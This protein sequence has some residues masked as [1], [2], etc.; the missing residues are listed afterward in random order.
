MFIQFFT[1]FIHA[2]YTVFQVKKRVIYI[3]LTA[4][5]INSRIRIRQIGYFSVSKA[6]G[7]VFYALLVVF[8][9]KDPQKK[10]NK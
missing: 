8:G 9:H 1:S 3:F 10:F 5:G 7:L 4:A 6:S 2:R